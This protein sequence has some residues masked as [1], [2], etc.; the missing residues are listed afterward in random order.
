MLL[1]SFLRSKKKKFLSSDFFRTPIYLVDK[2]LKEYITEI[3]REVEDIDPR[4]G[5]GQL[6]TPKKVKM[7]KKKKEFVRS[8]G[9]KKISG[10]K[11]SRKETLGLGLEFSGAGAIVGPM[12]PLGVKP[13][14][15]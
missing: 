1:I 4:A 11:K 14:D 5:D 10:K 15:R 7:L 3:L 8:G 9:K 12:M 2:L 6:L 13:D